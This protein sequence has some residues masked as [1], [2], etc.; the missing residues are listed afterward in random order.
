MPRQGA[1]AAV[2]R[3]TSD[4][5][6]LAQIYSALLPVISHD[7]PSSDSSTLCNYRW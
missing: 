4:N 3:P 1:V 2:N 6:P 5:M 7:R